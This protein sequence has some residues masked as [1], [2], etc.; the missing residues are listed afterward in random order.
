MIDSTFRSANP[1]PSES[2]KAEPQQDPDTTQTA[3]SSE[4]PVPYLDYK[5]TNHK[6]FTVEYF[7]LG[8]MWDDKDGGFESEINIIEDYMYH[9]IGDGQIANSTEAVKEKIR[10]LEKQAGIKKFDTTTNRISKITAFTKFLKE[11]ENL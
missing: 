9:L 3:N 1:A 2:P 8:N 7:E 11:V 4:V 6:P 5:N 10:S